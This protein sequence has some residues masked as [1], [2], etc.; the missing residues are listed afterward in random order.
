MI[1]ELSRGRKTEEK[2]P[3]SGEKWKRRGR[4]RQMSAYSILMYRQRSN[5]GEEECLYI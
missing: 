3:E 2:R 5:F 1:L 4:N